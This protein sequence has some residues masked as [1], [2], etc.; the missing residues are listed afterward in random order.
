MKLALALLLLLAAAAASQ[1][2]KSSFRDVAARRPQVFAP[3]GR[4]ALLKCLKHAKRLWQV[5]VESPEQFRAAVSEC[6]RRH[7][8]ALRGAEGR[9][10]A[11]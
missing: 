11:I 2:L 7:R 4:R 8:D 10:V 9:K 6:K 3:V 1:Q 5:E